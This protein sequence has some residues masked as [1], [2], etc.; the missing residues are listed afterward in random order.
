MNVRGNVP[1]TKVSEIRDREQVVMAL[2]NNAMPQDDIRPPLFHCPNVVHA[3]DLPLLYN[4]ASSHIVTCNNFASSIA[5]RSL[6]VHF[7]LG[8]W[9]LILWLKPRTQSIR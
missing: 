6:G 2:V 5:T 8:T 9:F 7:R 1:L 4:E 3:N